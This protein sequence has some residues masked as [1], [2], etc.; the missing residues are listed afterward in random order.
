MARFPKAVEFAALSD[1]HRRCS[2]LKEQVDIGAFNTLILRL[3][4]A[5]GVSVIRLDLA[6]TDK[7]DFSETSPIEPSSQGGQKIVDAILQTLGK[8]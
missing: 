3:A 6:C 4:E 5:R 8:G 7:Q 2:K 1:N